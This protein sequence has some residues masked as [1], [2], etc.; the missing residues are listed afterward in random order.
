MNNVTFAVLLLAFLSVCWITICTIFDAQKY[1]TKRK[2]LKNGVET[3]YA[4]K[5]PTP[6]FGYEA[7]HE[8]VILTHEEFTVQVSQIIVNKNGIFLIVDKTRSGHIIGREDDEKWEQVRSGASGDIIKKTMKNPI[9]EVKFQI[10]LLSRKLKELDCG[11]WIQGII[12][13]SHP[14]VSLEVTTS[15]IPVIKKDQLYDYIATY[16]P[17]RPIDP[18]R[19]KKINDWLVDMHRQPLENEPMR[20]FAVT[21]EV[22]NKFGYEVPYAFKKDSPIL[23]T[24]DHELYLSVIVEGST[25]QLVTYRAFEEEVRRYIVTWVN[26]MGFPLALRFTKTIQQY[27][28]LDAADRETE[29]TIR[30]GD[31]ELRY[32]GSGR[33]G[34][35]KIKLQTISKEKT[36]A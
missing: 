18:G 6:L 7:T 11:V 25:C 4:A 3:G 23:L 29:I 14:R 1:C 34:S 24:K 2:Y 12:V 8:N 32:W 10:Y 26:K 16:R 33:Y 21:K 36:S 5:P 17:R 31:K 13:F 22:A 35:F 20:I 19:L 15:E 28:E 30:E 9:R 27:I